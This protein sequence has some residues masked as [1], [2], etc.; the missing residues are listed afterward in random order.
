MYRKPRNDVGR[1]FEHSNIL[2]LLKRGIVFSFKKK[3]LLAPFNPKSSIQVFFHENTER[4]EFG[5]FGL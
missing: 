2:R 3:K 1:T 5:T 4:G